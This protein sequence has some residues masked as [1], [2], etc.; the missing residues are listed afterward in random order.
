ME[1]PARATLAVAAVPTAAAAAAAAAAVGTVQGW[2]FVRSSLLGVGAA[3]CPE[4]P[5]LCKRWGCPDRPLLQE[6]LI[7]CLPLCWRPCVQWRKRT[8]HQGARPPSLPF[9]H[10][11]S[12]SSSSSSSRKMN[13]WMGSQRTHRLYRGLCISRGA[14]QRGRGYCRQR[15]KQRGLGLR[16]GY[17]PHSCRS[18]HSLH[19][20]A[21]TEAAP[22]AAAVTFKGSRSLLSQV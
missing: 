17:K 3:E 19:S 12:S 6:W 15:A 21:Q 1:D 14:K 13:C 5:M 20:Q 7:E 18:L 9:Q 22:A 16:W 4:E 2:E 11:S 10:S 8:Y